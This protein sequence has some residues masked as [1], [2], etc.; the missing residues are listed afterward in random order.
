MRNLPGSPSLFTLDS[1]QNLQSGLI[2]F[3]PYL[4]DFICGWG[5]VAKIGHGLISGEDLIIFGF[6]GSAHSK[7]L[8][9]FWKSYKQK[10]NVSRLCSKSVIFT[11]DRKYNWTE[12]T[13]E[14]SRHVLSERNGGKDFG[15]LLW[16]VGWYF[17]HLSHQAGVVCS[18]HSDLYIYSFFKFQKV[19]IWG[20]HSSTY[21]RARA[22]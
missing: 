10:K 14:F 4:Q 2:Q 9:Q 20:Y 3:R 13:C 6:S 5:E 22:Y 16:N 8:F 17:S 11:S 18:G 21:N 12:H 19:H 1:C 7:C 15:T